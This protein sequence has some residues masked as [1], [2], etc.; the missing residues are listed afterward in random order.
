MATST[1]NQWSRY[2][3]YPP[4]MLVFGSHRKIAV[5]IT[6]DTQI[7]AHQLAESTCAGGI[8]FRTELSI[9]EAARKA[10]VSVDNQQSLRRAILQR[11]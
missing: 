3:G 7:S 9:R 8:R 4:E 5:S 6:S 10:F 2:R 1:K 11:T